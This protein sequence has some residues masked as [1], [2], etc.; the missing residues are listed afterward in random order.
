MDHTVGRILQW[1]ITQMELK[2]SALSQLGVRRDK[3]QHSSA[4]SQLDCSLL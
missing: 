3:K 4:E 1:E 2:Y